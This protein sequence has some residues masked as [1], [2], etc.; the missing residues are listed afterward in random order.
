MKSVI[1][2]CGFRCD[3]CPAFAQNADKLASKK[4]INAGWKKYFGF[5]VPEVKLTCEGCPKASCTLDPH[6]TIRPCAEAKGISSCAECRR[7]EAC[8]KLKT[9]ADIANEIKKKFKGNIPPRDI[10]IFFTP[11]EGRK[12]LNKLRKT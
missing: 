5:T 11:Y 3:L 12:N 2:Y 7:F 10:K 6:C 4:K 1:A 8:P 9:R